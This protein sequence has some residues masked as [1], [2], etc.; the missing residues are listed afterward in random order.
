MGC[1][2]PQAA[3]PGLSAL[4]PT[5]SYHRNPIPLVTQ[6]FPEVQRH[7]FSPAGVLMPLIGPSGIFLPVVERRR[8]FNINDRI[9]EL[10]MLIPKAND[11]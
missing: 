9:K 2:L 3:L 4:V 5:L 11:L 10:G 1:V 8:R 7:P 6:Y